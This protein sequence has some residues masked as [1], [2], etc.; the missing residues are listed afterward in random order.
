MT[1]QWDAFVSYASTDL[2]RVLPVAKSLESA[3]ITLWR[4][5]D[6]ILGGECYGSAIVSAIRSSRAL[7]VMCSNASLGSRNVRQEI[8]LAWKYG[9]PYLP[10]LLE[11]VEYT[12]K[13]EYWL[14]GS[15]WIEV[16]D[17]PADHWLPR[18]QAA[19][20]QA[21]NPD[22]DA[23]PFARGTQHPPNPTRF[24]T[25]F[26]GLRRIAAFTDR[27]WPIAAEHA[28]TPKMRGLGAAQPAMVHRYRLGSQ[29]RIQID[30]ERDAYLTLLDE[31]PEGIRYCLCPSLF[32]PDTRIPAGRVTLPQAASPADSFL[33]TGVPGREHLFAVLS[34]EPLDLDWG[35]HDPNV[36]ARVLSQNDI[37]TLL[38][39]VRALPEGSWTVLCTYFDIGA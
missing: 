14:E 23:A 31:G 4:D 27:I 19:L 8:L 28:L 32:A 18:V 1:R 6:G 5:K 29:V 35:S 34:D 22:A 26:D 13:I 30:C 33:L 15:Q 10:L 17:H 11:T 38:K 21:A 37:K 39:R 12:E 3:G 25:G 24:D 2:Q 20:Q 7:I 9:I 36:P 16:L